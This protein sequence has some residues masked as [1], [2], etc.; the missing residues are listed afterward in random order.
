MYEKSNGII[1]VLKGRRIID[2]DEF[3]K[4]GFSLL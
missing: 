4:K 2:R 1:I 3:K